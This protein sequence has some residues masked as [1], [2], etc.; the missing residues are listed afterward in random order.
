MKIESPEEIAVYRKITLRIL[1]ILFICFLLNY[2]DRVNVSF[3]KFEMLN[4]LHFSETIYGLGVGLFFIAYFFFMVPSNLILHR[5]GARIWIAILMAF[6]GIV[7]AS[8]L[9][10]TTPLG[11]YINRF[12]LGIAEA[13]FFPGV[14]LYLTYWYPSER[15]ARVVAG[16]VSGL[17]VANIVSGPIAGWI[18]T[19]FQNVGSLRSWQ[20][21]FLLEGIP[22]V[23]FAILLPLLLSSKI[24]FAAWLSAPEKEILER[25]LKKSTE[26]LEEHA[27]LLKVFKDSRIW[28][29]VLLYFFIVIVFYSISFYLPTF[30]KEVGVESFFHVGLFSA[31][32]YIV[33][34][35]VMFPIAKSADK[36]RERRWH[37]IIPLLAG[38]CGL[39]GTLLVPHN[40]IGTVLFFSLATAGI[41][42][43]LVAFWSLPTAFL[44]GISSAAG[45]ALIT[46]VGNLGGFFGPSIIGFIKDM[47][48]SSIFPIIFL[49][50]AM[51]LAGFITFLVPKSLVNK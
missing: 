29:M 28:L 25:R 26:G 18:M 39:L 38:G 35:V 41:L 16:F 12:I 11:F 5:I 19:H 30:I 43:A 2:L 3:A 34:M 37:L 36:R 9:L 42:S 23:L 1:P 6:W 47:T 46:C 8:T 14:I 24:Q 51:F 45:I 49:A 10:V 31:I 20:W 27:S 33:A 15:R 40:V 17:T 32:P 44:T 22:S 50:I 13:G 21:L 4:D 48:H 7:S